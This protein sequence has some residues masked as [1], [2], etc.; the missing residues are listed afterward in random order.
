MFVAAFTLFY[1]KH[2]DVLT[3]HLSSFTV[4]PSLARSTN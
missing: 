3:G 2:A 1:F 4:T